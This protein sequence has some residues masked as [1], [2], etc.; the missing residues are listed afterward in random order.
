M[1]RAGFREHRPGPEPGSART[2]WAGMTLKVFTCWEAQAPLV[3][4]EQS[5]RCEMPTSV[6][7]PQT[8]QG[9]Q[10]WVQAGGV[11]G[12]RGPWGLGRALFSQLNVSLASPSRPGHPGYITTHGCYLGEGGLCW[13]ILKTKAKNITE[14]ELSLGWLG[15]DGQPPPPAGGRKT[16]G[17]VSSHPR[18]TGRG[19]GTPGLEEVLFLHGHETDVFTTISICQLEAR[20]GHGSVQESAIRMVRSKIRKEDEIKKE[21]KGSMALI[22]DSNKPRA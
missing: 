20:A 7:G 8:V 13:D 6:L 18:S 5:W 11:A 19:R 3:R 12:S 10:G 17:L 16:R 21:R 4:S 22:A 2:L 14:A 9:C 1:E 15:G